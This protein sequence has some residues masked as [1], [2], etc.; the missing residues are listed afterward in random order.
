MKL[1][2][3]AELPSPLDY[4]V[5]ES[6][7]APLI[8][9]AETWQL[10]M[11]RFAENCQFCHGAYAISSGVIPDLRW[12]GI[13]ASE[14]SWAAIVRDGALT[15]NGMVGFA[16]IID[17]AEIE[18]IRHYVLRQAWLAVENGTADAPEVAALG[19]Q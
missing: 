2:G 18:A 1:G 5:V 12:S 16:D 15:D 17:D 19:D 9:D 6:P 8:G 11:Q 14:D 10:G 4:L 3:K 7:K 13:S